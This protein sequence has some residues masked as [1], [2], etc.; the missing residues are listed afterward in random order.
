MESRRRPDHGACGAARHQSRAR[1]S[2]PPD[3]P[4]MVR[5]SWSR[6]NRRSSPAFRRDTRAG[7]A[8]RGDRSDQ[9][10]R[11]VEDGRVDEVRMTELLD[12]ILD[13]VARE[14]EKHDCIVAMY[15]FGSLVRGDHTPESDLDLYVEYMPYDQMVAD[16]AS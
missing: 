13:E 12:E 11:R 3:F 2:R 4:E 15:I 14:A 6:F 1:R 5:R 8:S 16:S 10:A 7:C 9:A